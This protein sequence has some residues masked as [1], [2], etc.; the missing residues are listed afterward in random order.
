MKVE[1]INNAAEDIMQLFITESEFRKAG[2]DEEYNDFAFSTHCF[3]MFFGLDRII[4][5]NEHQA[6]LKELEKM[7]L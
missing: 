1:F 5:K 3:F 7:E 4:Y 6:I 2:N